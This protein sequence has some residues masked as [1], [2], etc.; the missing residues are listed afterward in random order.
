MAIKILAF[1]G[2]TR[3]DSLNKKL[4]K[5][6]AEMAKSAGAEITFIDLRD[7]PLPLYDGDVE[8]QAF[9]ENALKLKKIF[10][11]HQGLLIASPE[12]NSS[13]SAV[14][15]NTIDWVSRPHGDEGMLACFAGK[16]AAIMAVSPGALGGLRGLVP[17][18]MLLE[19]IMVSVQPL[20]VAVSNGMHA[21]S[22]D[23][24]KL[25]DAGQEKNIKA[26]AESLVN[27]M[28]KLHA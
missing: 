7:Y 8:A 24:S 1:A 28:T 4:V 16:N 10:L 20:Q 9:P 2:S 22:E 18:R 26:L 17:L 12:Y 3:T 25:N 27:T 19:N 14:L 6:A 11:E 5:V 13:F 15:K 21:F 23:G